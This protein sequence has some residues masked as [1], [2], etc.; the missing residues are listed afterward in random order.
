MKQQ[1]TRVILLS[2]LVLTWFSLSGLGA[3]PV[4]QALNVKVQILSGQVRLVRAGASVSEVATDIFPVMAGDEI[5]T[6]TDARAVV[7]YNDGTTM[8]MKPQTK[9]QIEANALRVFKGAAWFKFVKRG[10]E[11]VIETP[12]LV[13][14]IRGTQFDINV[15]SRMKTIL[16]VTE[17]AVAVRPAAAKD[18]PESL[19]KAGYATQ[20]EFGKPVSPTQVAI[21]VNRKNAEWADAAWRKGAAGGP[22]LDQMFHQAGQDRK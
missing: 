18:A 11:F 3:D 7:V 22:S 20:C 9:V 1:S 12:S 15:T 6:L 14:G 16:A 8:R 19:V 4:G 17:G 5:E 10:T 21:D 13:A 2:V